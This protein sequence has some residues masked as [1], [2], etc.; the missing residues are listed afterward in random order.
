MT[1]YRMY[2]TSHNEE[3]HKDLLDWF[4][5]YAKINYHGKI[6]PAVRE[7][8]ECLMTMNQRYGHWRNAKS[9]PVWADDLIEK[10]EAIVTKLGRA[11]V[12]IADGEEAE[13]TTLQ[14]GDDFGF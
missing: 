14:V 8:I 1:E 6:S 4:E 10:V 13:K 7:A 2:N 3:T 11:E 12:T 9:K 5:N